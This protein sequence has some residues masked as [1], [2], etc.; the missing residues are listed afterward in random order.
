MRVG[1]AG[2][3][4]CGAAGGDPPRPPSTSLPAATVLPAEWPRVEDSRRPDDHGV[5]VEH[6]YQVRGGGGRQVGTAGGGPEAHRAPPGVAP[7]LHNKGPAAVAAVTLSVRVPI[8]A[9]GR[10]LL[11]L[12]DVGTEGD[13]VCAPPP[14]L[15]AMRVT[16]C[17]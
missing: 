6:I 8:A 14:D 12:L 9:G 5:R 16:P 10:A 3:R 13:V 1:A 15:N 11:H 17:G 7:Q 4:G 2:L